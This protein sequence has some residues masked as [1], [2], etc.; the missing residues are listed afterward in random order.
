MEMMKTGRLW[1]AGLLG[2]L[3]VIGLTSAGQAQWSTAQL[4][5]LPGEAGADVKTSRIAPARGGGFHGIYHVNNRIRYRRYSGGTLSA[6]IDVFPGTNFMANGSIAE[7]LDGE[8]HVVFEDWASDNPEV[9]WYKSINGGASFPFTQ[10]LSATGGCAKHPQI[11]AYGTGNSAEMIMSYFRSGSTGGCDKSLYFARY[12]GSA[13]T[14]EADMGSNSHSEYDC[15]GMARSPL[16]GSV[17]RSFDPD[18]SSMAMRRYTGSWGSP[19]SLVSGSWPVRQHMA[20]SSSG[21]LMLMWDDTSRI[22]SQLY[23]PGVGPG[24]VIDVCAGGYSGSCDVCWLPGTNDFYMVIARETGTDAFHVYGR[25][26]TA[27]VWSGEESVMNGQTDA[28]TVTP[29]VTADNGGALYCIWE[30]W[31]SGKPQQWYAVKPSSLPPGP[32]GTISGV[33]HDNLG[34]GLPGAAITVTGVTS[35]VTQ[36]NGSY[37]M[38]V[39]VGTHT[40]DASKTFYTGQTIGSVV[41]SENQT[42]TVNFTLTTQP[43]GPVGSLTATPGNGM[44]YLTWTNS[45]SPSCNGVVIRCSTTGYPAGP[46]DGQ[47]LLDRPAS[48]G[49]SDSFTHAGLTNGVR[50]YYSAFAY[51]QDASRYYATTAR[52]GSASPSGVAD[53]DRDGDVDQADFG[54]FQECLSGSLIPQTDPA[55][56]DA[57]LDDMD[58]DVDL[59]DFAI[60]MRCFAGAGAPEDPD[61]AD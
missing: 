57:R 43:P 30:Y 44:N 4:F 59:D 38:L 10:V 58:D 33:V 47:L 49:S 40:V 45:T 26:W 28:F 1:I 17:Y 18:G 8:I 19:I 35:S 3:V 23:T 42:T 46:A 61:C 25:R 54:H 51:F 52:T 48:P 11:A 60:F 41:V 5:N 34:A 7:A 2:V 37:S 13:W 21:Q 31:G 27:G 53:Y 39:P 29:A 14:A 55:C 12:N 32:K 9:R 56:Q 15:F 6:P 22:K 16:D 50:I 36:S 20:I 24:P